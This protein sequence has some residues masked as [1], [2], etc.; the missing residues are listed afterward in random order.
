LLKSASERT[1]LIV[2]THSEKLIDELSDEPESVVVC[3][4]GDDYG[5]VF[6]RLSEDG[7]KLW[8]ENYQLGELWAK[9]EIGGTRW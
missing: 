5:T 3:E 9:G 4:R 6:K 7:L 8:L 1:Q 2:T